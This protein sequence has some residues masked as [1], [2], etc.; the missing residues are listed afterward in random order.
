MSAKV[1]GL[2]LGSPA[3][4]IAGA[5]VHYDRYNICKPVLMH[6]FNM[7]YICNNTVIYGFS[8]LKGVGQFCKAKILYE[9]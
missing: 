4:D 2:R 7:P 6:Y 8:E 9:M 1:V 3:V 5:Q